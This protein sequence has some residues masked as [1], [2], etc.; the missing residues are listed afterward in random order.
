MIPLMKC[1]C[2]DQPFRLGSRAFPFPQMA[3]G[4]GRRMQLSGRKQA[5]QSC[6]KR[7]TLA[8]T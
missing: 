2:I 6:R 7:L 1:G 4:N 5:I 8:A 3:F